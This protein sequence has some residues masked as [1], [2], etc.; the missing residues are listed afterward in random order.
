MHV[1]NLYAKA[2]QLLGRQEEALKNVSVA[3]YF[4]TRLHLKRRKL[5][6]S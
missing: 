5:R 4:P 2:E 6:K 1:K 3:Q